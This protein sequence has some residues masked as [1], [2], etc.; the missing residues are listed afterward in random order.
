MRIVVQENTISKTIKRLGEF[1]GVPQ[2][3]KQIGVIALAGVLRNFKSG[4]RSQSGG[5]GTWK[6]LAA[7]TIKRRRGGSSTPLRD[8]GIL[9]NGIHPEFPGNRVE[10]STAD[11]A[12]KY[13]A[14]QHYGSKPAWAIRGLKIPARPYMMITDSD[15][16]EMNG[17][18]KKFKV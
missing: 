11:Q 9:M 14:H 18:Y 15:V 2:V 10:I 7:S 4:G 17:I 8:T 1:I 6:P 16:R 5:K 3:Q 12:S 13:A